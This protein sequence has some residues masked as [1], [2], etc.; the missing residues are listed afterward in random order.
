V[1]DHFLGRELFDYLLAVLV[2]FYGASERAIRAHVAEAFHRCFPDADQFLP[3]DATYY[4]SSD[5]LPGNDYRLER[6]PQAPV[7][8]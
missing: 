8:R 6:C 4:F 1:Y 7:W 3:R 5:L 2:R